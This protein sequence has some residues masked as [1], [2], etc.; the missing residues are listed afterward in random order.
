VEL[1][2]R[3]VRIFVQIHRSRPLLE[4]IGVADVRKPQ[5]GLARRRV[6]LVLGRIKV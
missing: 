4:E 3:K 1:R 6:L 2:F 5:V